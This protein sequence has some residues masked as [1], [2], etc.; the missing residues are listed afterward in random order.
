MFPDNIPGM[1]P[2][3]EDI[4]ICI[5]VGTNS[6]LCIQTYSVIQNFIPNDGIRQ[7]FLEKLWITAIAPSP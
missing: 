3:G 6:G 2:F 1:V 5:S 7:R 4:L